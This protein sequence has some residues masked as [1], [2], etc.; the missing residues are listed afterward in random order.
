[1][2]WNSPPQF[3]GVLQTVT[4]FNSYIRDNLIALKDP[5]SGLSYVSGRN[6]QVA[7]AGAWTA[8][9]TALV[10]GH[11]QHTITLA[12]TVAVA[13]F[14]GSV[15][16]KVNNGEIGFNLAVN[17][18]EYFP[19]AGIA[20]WDPTAMSANVI[21]MSFRAILT[22]L[23][24]GSLTVRLD[25]SATHTAFLLF[26]TGVANRFMPIMFYVSESR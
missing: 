6:Y 22:G 7:G 12:G 19:G 18:V 17:G 20:F 25:W 5:P 1:M 24:P 3:S 21:P 9:D 8:V 11:L 16:P 23:T 15:Q 2:A 14:Q 10:A 4:A 13:E 26:G